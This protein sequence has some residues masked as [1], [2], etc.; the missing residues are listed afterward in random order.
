MLHHIG[1]GENIRR[2]HPLHINVKISLTIA[3]IA[4]LM[5]TLRKSVRN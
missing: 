2:K 4:T 3:V 1:K 5:A